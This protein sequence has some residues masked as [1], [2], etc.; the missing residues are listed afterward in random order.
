M[1]TEYGEIMHSIG[2][3]SYPGPSYIKCHVDL[4]SV[5][6]SASKD[7]QDQQSAVSQ[8]GNI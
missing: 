8:T 5:K 6:R 3:M 2:A 4:D 1:N 7:A